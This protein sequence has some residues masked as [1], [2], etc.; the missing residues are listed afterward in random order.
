MAYLSRSLSILIFV[1]YRYIHFCMLCFAGGSTI[2]GVIVYG[3]QGSYFS[4]SFGLAVIGG[5]IYGVAG[6]LMIL[7]LVR[8]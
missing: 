3:S 1:L 5:I 4:W 8:S 6:G 7:H 2:L